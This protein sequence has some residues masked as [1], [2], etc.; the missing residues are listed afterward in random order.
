MAQ[1]LRAQLLSLTRFSI[2][3]QSAA[4]IALAGVFGRRSEGDIWADVDGDM[5]LSCPHSSRVPHLVTRS[6]I[7]A[8][9]KVRLITDC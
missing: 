7:P 8:D 2:A 5:V 4:R 6:T 3:V 1:D 9:A